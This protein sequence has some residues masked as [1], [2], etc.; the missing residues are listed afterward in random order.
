MEPNK[1][2]E[3]INYGGIRRLD[4]FE[5]DPLVALLLDGIHPAPS[6]IREYRGDSTVKPFILTEAVHFRSKPRR[7]NDPEVVHPVDTEIRPKFWNKGFNNDDLDQII[8]I[9]THDWG[10]N[11]SRGTV[12][13]NFAI[14]RLIGHESVFGQQHYHPALVQ[15]NVRRTIYINLE[16]RLSMILEPTPDYIVTILTKLLGRVGAP[17]SQKGAYHQLKKRVNKYEEA[18]ELFE[19]GQK[20]K[21]E[22]K[23]LIKSLNLAEIQLHEDPL[24]AEMMKGIA[25]PY[26][27]GYERDVRNPNLELLNP[28][29]I[30]KPGQSVLMHNLEHLQYRHYAEDL[31]AY[32]IKNTNASNKFGYIAM[33]TKV[34]EQLDNVRKEGEKNP[35]RQHITYEK[36]LIIADVGK[37]YLEHL[38]NV[39]DPRALEFLQILD[40]FKSELLIRVIQDYVQATT[41]RDR[42]A[43]NH[44]KW[45]VGQFPLIKDG[46]GET[47]DDI[48]SKELENK[49]RHGD[50]VDKLIYGN[51][52]R[53]YEQLVASLK[54]PSQSKP[55]FMGK[56]NLF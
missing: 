49:K 25:K 14:V 32:A 9:Y 30:F 19:W 29:C 31:L 6:Q 8:S 28:N 42:D 11:L 15:T 12:D 3:P 55:L 33:K 35:Y 16:Q 56:F 47:I 36:A 21:E 18:I 27:K 4:E 34:Q 50:D 37:K 48:V 2:I 20:D 10:E 46:L 17:N 53:G 51:L 45:L 52:L 5:N 26:F 1:S 43:R 54:T 13:G 38:I 24:S 22:A 39:Q 23:E 40:Y 44:I 41:V 7:T